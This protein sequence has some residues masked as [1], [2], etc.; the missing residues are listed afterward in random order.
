M[1]TKE[2]NPIVDEEEVTH[3][4]KATLEGMKDFCPFFLQYQ[5]FTIDWSHC[6]SE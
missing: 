1:N 2:G 6:S 4:D 3:Q 5:R